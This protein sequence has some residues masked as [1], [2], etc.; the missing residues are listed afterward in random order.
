MALVLTLPV[1]KRFQMSGDYAIERTAGR[2]SRLV[3]GGKGHAVPRMQTG[4]PSTPVT[5]SMTCATA[6]GRKI[7]LDSD[8]A[9]RLVSS[10]T[11]SAP[12]TTSEH[13]TATTG[14]NLTR[15]SLGSNE[16]DEYAFVVVP[17]IGQIV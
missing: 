14:A 16:I 6:G 9:V 7:H 17:Q 11:T 3:G 15:E 1:Q 13:R 8:N 4:T 10:L 2:I 5:A 12:A